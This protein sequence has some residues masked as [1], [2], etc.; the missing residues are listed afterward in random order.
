MHVH[1]AQTRC[2]ANQDGYVGVC[3]SGAKI[4]CNN[5]HWPNIANHSIHT[6][7]WRCWEYPPTD[8]QR[9]QPDC[10][11]NKATP[12]QGTTFNTPIFVA[13][14]IAR[15]S[16]RDGQLNS[17]EH[18][19]DQARILLTFLR[20]YVLRRNPEERRTIDPSLAKNAVLVSWQR[21]SKREISTDEVSELETFS[22][23][24]LSQE[25]WRIPK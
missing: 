17:R 13:F 12:L 3:W 5:R 6:L 10:M 21:K 23:S 25:A 7:L 18:N 19:S 1:V 4:R 2:M 11:L 20:S 9:S 22:V 15:R 24:V 8:F 14:A 16:D